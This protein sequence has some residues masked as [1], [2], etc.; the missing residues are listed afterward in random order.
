MDRERIN[1]LNDFYFFYFIKEDNGISTILFFLHPARGGGGG[2]EMVLPWNLSTKYASQIKICCQRRTGMSAPLDKLSTETCIS[3]S[4]QLKKKEK[5]SVCVCVAGGGGE[6]KEKKLKGQTQTGLNRT[7][8]DFILLIFI[9][10][11]S[12]HA[13]PHMQGL[14]QFLL[15][16][17]IQSRSPAISN[18]ASQ[19]KEPVW[20]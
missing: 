12:P 9:V 1:E 7:T 19:I 8:W 15:C 20:S 10:K 6:E 13:L 16:N 17:L 11:S 3:P 4:R 5:K 14:Q 2:G 18:L